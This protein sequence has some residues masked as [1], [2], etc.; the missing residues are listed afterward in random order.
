M[1]I[2]NFSDYLNISSNGLSMN[3][4]K[5]LDDAI[6]KDIE[7]LKSKIND[8]QEMINLADE[9]ESD[10][11]EY[12]QDKIDAAK[13]ELM[14]L[15]DTDE[16]GLESI[17][18]G[19]SNGDGEDEELEDED[20]EPEPEPEDKEDKKINENF[21]PSEMTD[22]LIAI[23]NGQIKKVFDMIKEKDN[24]TFLDVSKVLIEKN[25]PEYLI[26]LLEM[27]VYNRYLTI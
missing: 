20:K 18:N 17:L 23:K 15:L 13:D 12:I 19:E 25:K 1:K 3:E 14:Y 5:E 24:V 22:V 21:N 2:A 11:V 26:R 10:F 16:D 6:N 4:S 7:D 9:H 27:A 8:F